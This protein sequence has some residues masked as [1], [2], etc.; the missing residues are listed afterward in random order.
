MITPVEVDLTQFHPSLRDEISKEIDR[1]SLYYP[2]YD[3][4]HF[5]IHVAEKMNKCACGKCEDEIIDAFATTRSKFDKTTGRWYFD[6]FFRQKWFGIEGD[7]KE[8]RELLNDD[9]DHWH[10]GM[11]G[12]DAVIAHEWGHVIDH[13]LETKIDALK[14]ID[15]EGDDQPFYIQSW[16]ALMSSGSSAL[17]SPIQ[18]LAMMLD[19]RVPYDLTKEPRL[20]SG[21][22]YQNPDEFFAETFAAL[23]HGDEKQKML[24]SVKHMEVYLRDAYRHVR[25][26]EARSMN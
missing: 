11:V 25:S 5:K 19:K 4:H 17:S 26:L 21:Y 20:V 14:H 1:L 16:K 22:A 3:A 7:V 23:H 13:V 8:L 9:H 12:V 2:V 6:I 24:P 15:D 10:G 18:M